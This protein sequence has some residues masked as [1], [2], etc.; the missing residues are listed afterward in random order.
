MEV[1]GPGP[2]NSPRPVN[3]PLV[4]QQTTQ[5]PK[6]ASVTPQDEVDISSVGRTMEDISKSPDIRQARLAQIKAAIDDGTYESQE[7]FDIAMS[8]LM[9]R[10]DRG[11]A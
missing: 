8:K 6:P 7:K 5:G 9:E 1:N 10:I 2:M 4:P 3:R 11:E